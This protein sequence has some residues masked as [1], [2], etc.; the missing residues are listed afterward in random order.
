M[1]VIVSGEGPSD[2]GAC[3][4]AQGVC[5]DGDFSPGPMVIWLARLWQALLNYDLLATPESV[6]YVSEKTL[7]QEAKQSAGRMQPIRGRRVVPG[8]GWPSASN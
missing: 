8:W 2:M 4:N 5:Y 3:N 1:R 7:A 6:I